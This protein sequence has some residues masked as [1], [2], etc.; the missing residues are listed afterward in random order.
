MSVLLVPPAYGGGPH[1]VVRRGKPLAVREEGKQWTR[2]K[3]YL[4]CSGVG[5]FLYATKAPKGGDFHIRARLSLAKLDSTAASLVFG[6]M[7]FGLDGQERRLFIEGGRFGKA[8]HLGDATAY[9]ADGKPFTV[10]I[11]CTNGIGV[12]SIDGTSYSAVVDALE[13]FVR[14]PRDGRP[15]AIVCN[16][17]KGYGAFAFGLNKHKT[18]LSTDI[19]HHEMARQEARR[20]WKSV[21]SSQ[22]AIAVI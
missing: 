7:H 5:N 21:T 14:L 4:E 1:Y 17:K 3:G 9:L 10:E 12:F 13:A 8:R 18:T 15:T 20:V 6:G 11:D 2:G 19:Y 16:T 22:K